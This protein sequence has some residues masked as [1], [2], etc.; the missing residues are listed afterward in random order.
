[1]L[2]LGTT[3]IQS[4]VA[5]RLIKTVCPVIECD[6][7]NRASLLRYRDRDVQPIQNHEEISDKLQRRGHSMKGLAGKLQ[8]RQDQESHRKMRKQIRGN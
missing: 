6:E 5:M 7:K 8:L 1:M 3:L 4:A 2:K